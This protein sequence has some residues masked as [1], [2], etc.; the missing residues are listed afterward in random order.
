M[1]TSNME[2]RALHEADP[3]GKVQLGNGGALSFI[4]M[5]GLTY[6]RGHGRNNRCS[7]YCQDVPPD[8]IPHNCGYHRQWLIPF[9]F[10]PCGD[11]CEGAFCVCIDEY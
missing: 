3:S 6:V 4:T 1:P 11:S 9:N 10:Q 8:L 7:P 2:L 5:G